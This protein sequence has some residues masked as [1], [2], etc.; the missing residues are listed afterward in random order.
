MVPFVAVPF[1][2]I[3]VVC[4]PFALSCP[5]GQ[6]GQVENERRAGLLLLFYQAKDEGPC[7]CSAQAADVNQKPRVQC[8]ASGLS[9]KS[10]TCFLQPTSICQSAHLPICPTTLAGWLEESEL[11]SPETLMEGACAEQCRATGAELD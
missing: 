4:T 7:P 6:K 10:G 2:S 11:G 3:D 1:N 8:R 5:I 9:G